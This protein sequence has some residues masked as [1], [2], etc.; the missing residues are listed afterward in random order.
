MASIHFSHYG[1][2]PL[3]V[4]LL[5]TGCQQRQSM[6][7]AGPPAQHQVQQ[8]ASLIAASEYLRNKCNRADIPA[9]DQ[10]MNAALRLAQKKSWDTNQPEYKQ[11]P[12]DSQKL[13]SALLNDGTP[14]D[15]QCQQFNLSIRPFIEAAR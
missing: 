11:L 1:I 2:I 6:R 9:P 8:L 10:L 4:A 3:C 13:Y 5:C 7:D 15:Q 14:V 12:I